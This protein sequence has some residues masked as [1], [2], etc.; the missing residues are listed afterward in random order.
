MLKYQQAVVSSSEA[1][2]KQG[3]L[4][5]KTGNMLESDYLLL[6]AQY[7]SD[8]YNMVNAEISRQYSLLSL[9][10]LLA[11]STNTNIELLVPETQMDTKQMEMPALQ[12]VIEQTLSWFPDIK[13]AQGD[14]RIAEYDTKIA[15]GAFLPNLSLNGSVGSGYQSGFGS[16]GTQVGK[17]FNEQLSINLSVPI[18]SKG[19]NA[20][21]LQQ[22]KIRQEQSNLNAQ[23]TELSVRRALEQAYLKVIGNAKQYEASQTKL[24]ACKASYDAYGNMFTAGSITAVD[25]LQQQSTYLNALNEYIQAK[26]AY[27]LNRKVINVYMGY[28]IQ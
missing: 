20:S 10:E 12:E 1:Q 2:W 8:R 19:Q 23:Q 16:W 6:K 21:S 13:I 3:E 26:Y 14:I 7:E 18:W 15:R 11:L 25:L 22:A 27:L 9:K 24:N 28:N 4:R 5:W 17:G